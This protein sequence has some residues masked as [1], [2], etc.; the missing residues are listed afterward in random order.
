LLNAHNPG[1]VYQWQDGSTDSTFLANN[2]GTYWVSVTNGYNCSIVD[3]I[4]LNINPVPQVNLGADTN[5]CNGT[6]FIADAGTGGTTYL[7]STGNNSQTEPITSSGTFWVEV[8]NSY[9]CKSTD[10][11]NV[12]INPVPFVDLGENRY[13]CSNQYAVLNAGNDGIIYNWFS[14]NGNISSQ[15]N[16]ITVND[17]GKYWVDV[18]NTYGCK[19]SDTVLIQF[20]ELSLTAYFLAPTEA[21]VGD[22][23]QFVDVSYPTPTSYSWNFK[24]GVSSTEEDPIHIYYMQDT[25]RVELEVDN[26]VCS[27]TISKRIIIEGMNRFYYEEQQEEQQEDLFI[28]IL[29]S[30]VYPNPNRGEFNYA[31]E[32]SI[33]T[34]VE[35]SIFN[36]NG[37]MLYREKIKNIK[38][39]N[40]FYQFNNLPQGLYLFKMITGDQKRVYK[41]V[42]I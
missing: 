21:K 19:A 16:Y 23:I 37:R 22:T 8:T 1:A 34:D 35:L 41:I 33:K 18:E 42:K 14:S 2:S 31:L 28:E 40:R 20:S 11:I 5:L 32:L 7:W 10:T 9:N 26:S 39:L 17:S 25:F 6:E 24:D 12:S 30:V 38:S 15:A 13:L 29:K 36:L 3:S 27:D 4:N